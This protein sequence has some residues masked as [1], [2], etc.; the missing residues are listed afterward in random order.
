MTEHESR[1]GAAYIEKSGT[2]YPRKFV[3]LLL[4]K[5]RDAMPNLTI[6]TWT[7]VSKIQFDR[8]HPLPYRLYTNC[9]DFR[10]KTIFHATNALRR[11]LHARKRAPITRI[12]VVSLEH[13]P[14]HTH[15][16]LANAHRE[17]IRLVFPRR[18]RGER[19]VS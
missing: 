2:F 3:N 1:F 7:N 9:G 10:S 6:H 13:Q 12:D 16:R 11:A 8:A 14:S 19:D 18:V 15:T 17:P 5:A 4:R